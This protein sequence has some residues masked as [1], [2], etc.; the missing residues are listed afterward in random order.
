MKKKAF[1]F[2]V[3]AIL[4][5]SS[6]FIHNTKKNNLT[7]KAATQITE[8][9]NFELQ[10]NMNFLRAGQLLND[11]L[12]EKE[13]N[14]IIVQAKDFTITQHEANIK[15][16]YY[17]S[18]ES[19]NP[20]QDAID[21]CIRLETLYCEAVKKG[22]DV[23]DEEVSST[24]NTIKQSISDSND[25][26]IKSYLSKFDNEEDYWNYEKT[27]VRYNMIIQK[28]LTNHRLTFFKEHNFDDSQESQNAWLDAE[29]K[30]EKEL[31]KKQKPQFLN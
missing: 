18:N 23:S 25:N 4:L 31:I 29:K 3:F 15:Y 27:I 11:V 30:L 10:P 9:N 2:F 22:F 1:F 14:H 28:Y 17:K 19:T 12:K 8:E 5:F 21:E 16:V 24:V 20:M 7:K 6:A 26:N 13:D